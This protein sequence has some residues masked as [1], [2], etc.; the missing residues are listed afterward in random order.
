M[1]RRVSY[2]PKLAFQNDTSV[3]SIAREDWANLRRTEKP[4]DPESG[5]PLGI[6]YVVDDT[7]LLINIKVINL[8]LDLSKF[9]FKNLKNVRIFSK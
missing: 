5:E 6:E 4:V 7:P 3:S 9:H 8:L 2:T 1:L